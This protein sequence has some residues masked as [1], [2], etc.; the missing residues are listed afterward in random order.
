MGAGPGPTG[1][2]PSTVAEARAVPLARCPFRGENARWLKSPV[3]PLP[4][5]GAP[6]SSANVVSGSAPGGAAVGMLPAGASP[7]AESCVTTGSPVTV[8][9]DRPPPGARARDVRGLA[10]RHRECCGEFSFTARRRLS[11]G[12]R[13]GNPPR[14]SRRPRIPHLG[15]FRS[16]R[17]HDAARAVRPQSCRDGGHHRGF[18]FTHFVQLP[19]ATQH[20]PPF[21]CRFEDLSTELARESRATGNGFEDISAALRISSRGRANA[22]QVRC[23]EGGGPAIRRR[24]RH[25]WRPPR[26]PVRRAP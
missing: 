14:Y 13:R 10:G 4:C 17:G 20:R 7:G 22:P 25:P 12:P 23:H 1:A 8:V 15:S 16:R 19:S 24:G 6:G 5:A 26:G 3:A 9:G 18:S 21:R 2:G 11:K